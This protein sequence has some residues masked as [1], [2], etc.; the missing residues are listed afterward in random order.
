MH[1]TNVIEQ[2]IHFLIDQAMLHS[3]F[4]LREK[5]TFEINIAFINKIIA[6]ILNFFEKNRMQSKIFLKVQKNNIMTRYVS[7][8]N[9]IIRFLLR[10]L[11]NNDIC[12]ILTTRYLKLLLELSDSFATIKQFIEALHAIN[13]KQLNFQKCLSA[14]DL[15][16]ISNFENF[17]TKL[18]K[19][20]RLHVI[21]LFHAFDEFFNQ[22]I[23]WYSCMNIIKDFNFLMIE[24]IRWSSSKNEYY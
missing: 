1:T 24:C 18:F 21:D 11:T 4:I 6:C 10:L 19:S 14:F 13:S 20:L 12:S 2:T 17:N 23:E 7:L 8:W 5:V 16:A 3:L 15:D 22:N 9:E